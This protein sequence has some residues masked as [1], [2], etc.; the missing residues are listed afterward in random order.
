MG[1]QAAGKNVEFL[2]TQRPFQKGRSP[3]PI[4]LPEQ[5]IAPERLDASILLLLL[6]IVE[7]VAAVK[8]PP[9][10]LVHARNMEAMPVW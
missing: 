6:C 9:P 5:H 8:A 7:A 10:A 3:P 2:Y 4:F 1:Q